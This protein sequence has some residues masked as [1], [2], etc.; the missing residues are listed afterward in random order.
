ME[1]RLQKRPEDLQV[2]EKPERL[3]NLLKNGQEYKM[4]ILW[5]QN[6]GNYQQKAWSLGANELG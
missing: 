3:E 6:S 1:W 4:F 5:S 2:I